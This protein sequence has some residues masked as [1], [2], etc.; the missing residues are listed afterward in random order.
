MLCTILGVDRKVFKK[1]KRSKWEIYH[2]ILTAINNEST[3]GY[4]R[5]TRIQFQSNMSYNNLIHYLTELESRQMI[6]RDPISLTQK[7]FEYFRNCSAVK[8]LV[9]K[10]GLDRI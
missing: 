6:K 7:G 2:D 5:P 1:D 10:L 8:D 3:G 9:H 4:V